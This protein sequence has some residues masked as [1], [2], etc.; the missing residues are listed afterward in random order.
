[1]RDPK[2]V[3]EK[4][5]A[6]RA[7]LGRTTKMLRFR[8]W[9]GLLVVLSAWLAFV[10]GFDSISY[11]FCLVTALVGS[12]AA[13]HVG[14]G[15]VQVARR[16]QPDATM[17]TL[18][19]GAI[20]GALIL[21]HLPLLVISANALRVKVC[22]YGGGV[23]FW[24]IGPLISM[25]LAA[26]WGV[27]AGLWTRR[28]WTGTALFVAGMLVSFAWLA[29]HF[30]TAPQ[31]FAYSPFFGALNGAIY[32]DVIGI[33]GTLLLF[34][35]NNVVQLVFAVLLTR[36]ALDPATL[37]ARLARLAGARRALIPVAVA[38]AAVVTLFV[39]RGR[40][41]WEISA[42]DIQRELGGRYDTDHMTIWYPKDDPKLAADIAWIAEDH[43][44]RWQQLA[45]LIG[46]HPVRIESY[47]YGSSAQRRRL[48]GADK[49]YVAK[50]WLNQ[51]HLGRLPYGSGILHHELAHVF[52]GAYAPGPLHVTAQAWVLPHMALVEGLATAIEWDRGRLTPHQWSAAMQ[53]LDILPN[54]E[55][56]M[57][58]QGYLTTFG[59]SAYTTAGSL[60]R[61]LI[62]ERGMPAV[63][64]LYG[65]GDFEAAFGE[66]MDALVTEWKAFLR[67]RSRV[68]IAP[69][70]MERARFYFDRK[71]VLQRVC[72]I[73]VAS[74]ERE[75]G[76]SAKRGD[77][78]RAADIRRSV[79]RWMPLDPGKK[80]ALAGVLLAL[81]KDEE[82]RKLAGEVLQSDKASVFLKAAVRE[83]LADADWREGKDAEA[84][85]AY[86]EL[87]TA[88]LDQGSLRGI[89]V[90]L[91]SME[92]P[93][94]AVR[95]GVRDY[96]TKPRKNEEAL[97]LLAGLEAS[98]PGDPLV[99]YL[100]GRRLFLAARYADA[101]EPLRRA[102]LAAEPPT[103]TAERERMLGI[104]LYFAGEPTEARSH[105]SL[106]DASLPAGALG[107]RGE[108]QGWAERCTWKASAGRTTTDTANATM[109]VVAEPSQLRAAG[110]TLACGC[111]PRP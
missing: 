94:A 13:A 96:L 7:M 67:D 61:W 75:A 107:L 8:V 1:M 44:Y 33:S 24:F 103:V 84:R 93:T 71:G 60:V 34:R 35:V 101:L 31:I 63:L 104:A 25:S 4:Y 92:Q 39:M 45:A 54:I 47:V 42:A 110:E 85:A 15:V 65:T 81:G 59:G 19:R 21:A 73:V 32:D 88:P 82:A 69:E 78:Q 105:L 14:V 23:A 29:W 98:A 36:A 99:A 5:A 80:A 27:V 79:L 77:L 108:V 49:V 62:D 57:G 72:P 16:E 91:L 37:R 53:E 43:E 87:R 26:A 11:Y 28:S 50:P 95:D 56:I 64:R 9:A 22:D 48:M 40:L 106:S 52:V 66:P 17:G 55:R 58:P 68:P 3:A 51:I 97:A 10:P 12:I 83:Q 2:A 76:R 89:D 86:E 74:L 102:T 18:L 46:P 100:Y 20:G 111:G 90:K 30:Y 41:G 109:H 70:D 6:A 38:L